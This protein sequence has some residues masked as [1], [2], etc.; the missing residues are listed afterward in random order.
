MVP[1][2]LLNFTLYGSLSHSLK[3]AAVTFSIIFEYTK[4]SPPSLPLLFVYGKW[5]YL[6]LLWTGMVFQ[7]V[8]SPKSNLP[9]PPHQMSS[10]LV[11]LL[12]KYLP[13]GGL[14]NRHSEVSHSEENLRPRFVSF[15]RCEQE[16]LAGYLLSLACTLSGCFP[17]WGASAQ[18][19]PPP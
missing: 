8:L 15:K 11:P 12:M 13:L 9:W 17:L 18:M 5:S 3:P 4:F 2:K 19:C 16:S 14:N 10:C 6:G 1:S 7:W